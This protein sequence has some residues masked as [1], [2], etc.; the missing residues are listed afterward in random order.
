VNGVNVRQKIA[1][2][3][4]VPFALKYRIKSLFKVSGNLQQV[5]EPF[6][7]ARDSYQN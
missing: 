4:E 1:P 2:L 6:A 3:A 5:Q 7:H